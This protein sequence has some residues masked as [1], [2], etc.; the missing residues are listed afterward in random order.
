MG[1]SMGWRWVENSR[2]TRTEIWFITYPTSTCVESNSDLHAVKQS[3]NHGANIIF[4]ELRLRSQQ[5]TLDKVKVART[6]LLDLRWQWPDGGS[7]ANYRY[8]VYNISNIPQTKD[9]VQH[10]IRIINSRAVIALNLGT[11]FKLNQT[12]RKIINM[13]MC[14]K[15]QLTISLWL[16]GMGR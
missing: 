5:S 12:D 15:S 9:K 3:S 10:N 1:A 8:V 4:T 6:P 13:W 11:Q 2:L 7:W 14:I 16:H